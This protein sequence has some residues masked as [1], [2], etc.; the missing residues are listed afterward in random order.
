[1]VARRRV[2]WPPWWEWELELTSHLLKRM[3]DRRFSEL[4][5][6]TMMECATAFRTDKEPG[7]WVVETSHQRRAGEVI[8]EPDASD[9]LLVVITGYPLE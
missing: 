4:D 6:R 7:R 3:G 5:L 9:R 2:D 8:V 1:M